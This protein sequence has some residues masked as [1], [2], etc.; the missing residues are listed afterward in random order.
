MREVGGF[1]RR[2]P[3]AASLEGDLARFHR[4]QPG[5]GLEQGRFARAVRPQ[6]GDAMPAQDRHIEMMDRRHP[7]VSHGRVFYFQPE[8]FHAAISY[9]RERENVISLARAPEGLGRPARCYPAATERRAAARGVPA[10]HCTLYS[11]SIP[12]FG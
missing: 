8:R 11:R 10:G 5:D 6:Q 4:E 2:L 3:E 9:L 12:S 7:V 1:L